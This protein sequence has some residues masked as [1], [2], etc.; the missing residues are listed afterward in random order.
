MNRTSQAQLRI[1]LPTKTYNCRVGIKLHLSEVY[2]HGNVAIWKHLHSAR[3][4]YAAAEVW[5]RYH[6]LALCRGKCCK[7][8]AARI[9]STRIPLRFPS[10]HFQCLLRNFW[11]LTANNQNNEVFHTLLNIQ[12]ARNHGNRFN[13]ILYQSFGHYC[14]ARNLSYR[15]SKYFLATVVNNIG[16]QS[17]SFAL[18]FW[19][20]RDIATR[21]WWC[22]VRP[23]LI[24]CGVMTHQRDQ[25]LL[26][27]ML[28]TASHR[29][30]RLT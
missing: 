8:V 22:L 10:L 1:S 5:S 25:S 30:K 15:F 6:R 17:S 24:I 19:L 13:I 4:L 20:S 9:R 7:V 14:V 28:Y 29:S 18:F 3:C 12:P 26:I 16:K 23:S 27:H 21:R 11:L 2:R